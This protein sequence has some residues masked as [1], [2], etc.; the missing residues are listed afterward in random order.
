MDNLAFMA[1][2]DGNQYLY[3]TFTKE[4]LEAHPAYDAV[5]CAEKRDEQ[6]LKLTR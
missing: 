1:D 2:K 4:Q 6:V 3:T 5:T